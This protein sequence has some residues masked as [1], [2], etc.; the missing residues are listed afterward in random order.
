MLFFAS[1]NEAS[2]KV[3]IIRKAAWG[4]GGFPSDMVNVVMGIGVLVYSM[5]LGV[6]TTLIG[7]ALA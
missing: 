3:P 4:L 1:Q 2:A 6:S 5:H 7:I